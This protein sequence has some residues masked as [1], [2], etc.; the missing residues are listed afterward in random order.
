MSKLANIHSLGSSAAQVA[1]ELPCTHTA[2]ADNG[3]RF[4]S[5]QALA[6]RCMR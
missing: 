6:A 3:R 2:A 5:S 4:A 1:M